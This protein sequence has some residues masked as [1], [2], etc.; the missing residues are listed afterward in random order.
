MISG[1][2]MILNYSTNKF[3]IGRAVNLN[4]RWKTHKSALNRDIHTNEYLQFAWN[5]YEVLGLM[6]M[7]INVSVVNVEK[8]EIFIIEIKNILETEKD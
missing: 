2:Y 8:E 4:N 5:K 7:E 1:I 6:R 3:Y